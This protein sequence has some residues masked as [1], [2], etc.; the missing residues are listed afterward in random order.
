MKTRHYAAIT[1]VLIIVVGAANPVLAAMQTVSG[2]G[3]YRMG[4]YE[5][6]QEAVRLATER[7]ETRASPIRAPS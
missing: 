4:D 3:E 6:K 2:V 1:L 7:A 5:T